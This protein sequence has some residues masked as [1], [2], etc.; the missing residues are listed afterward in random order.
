MSTIQFRQVSVPEGIIDLGVGQPEESVFPTSRF[1]QAAAVCFGEKPEADLF[2]YGAEYG[3]G[4]HRVELARFLTDAY[5]LQVDPELL[6]TTNGNSQGLDMVCT[7]FA[8][9]G[10]VVIIEEPSYFL[11]HGIFRDHGLRIVGVPV[12][13]GGLSLQL[14][15]QTLDE[16]EREGNPARLLYTIPAFQNPTG[17]TLTQ[18][19]REALVEMARQRNVLI[20]ADEVYHLLSYETDPLPPAMSAWVESG[21]VISLGTFSKILAPGLRLGWAH[22]APDRVKEMAEA[23]LVASGGGLNPVVSAL[24]TEILRDGLNDHVAGLCLDYRQRVIVMEQALR[25]HLPAHIEWTRPNG[26]YFFWLDLG[27]EAAPLRPFARATGVDFRQG[28]LFSAESGLNNFARLCFAFYR[29]D[30]IEEGVR[31]LGQVL[32]A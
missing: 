14:L 3:D 24:V 18:N 23:G 1:A 13:E 10:D 11:A 19:R 29:E 32:K 22:A 17:V 27:R 7:V 21:P 2:Q 30:E 16:L 26:G 6:F 15:S 5:Q 9:P 25:R 12:D 8:R 20:V 28:E 31:R 4:H